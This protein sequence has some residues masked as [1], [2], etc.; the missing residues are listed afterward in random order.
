[1]ACKHF[2][3]GFS[4]NSQRFWKY[5]Q[6]RNWWP[7]SKKFNR[8]QFWSYFIIKDSLG[9]LNVRKKVI[10]VVFQFTVFHRQVI[11][12]IKKLPSKMKI[13][14]Q[15]SWLHWMRSYRCVAY[16][17]LQCCQCLHPVWN[18]SLSEWVREIVSHRWFVY[19]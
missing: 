14:L 18:E 9:I 3:R 13:A 7:Q 10:I 15:M 11:V 2:F 1:M 12:W 16:S 17:W 4:M 8:L 6:R 19:M 5:S